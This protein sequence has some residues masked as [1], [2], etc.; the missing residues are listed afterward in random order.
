MMD[1]G[2]LRN[3]TAALGLGALLYSGSVEAQDS[4]LNLLAATNGGALIGRTTELP[5]RTA[6]HLI[7]DAGAR[8]AW[9]SSE[10]VFPQTLTFRLAKNRPFNTIVID[11]AGDT[12]DANWAKSI[13]ISTADPFPHMGGWVSV[14]IVTLAKSAGDQ[15]FT[16]EKVSGRFIRLVIDSVQGDD[17][18]RV[19]LGNVGLF[20]R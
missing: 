9:A 5:D 17:A 3:A 1:T 2:R 19:S 13:R 6:N 7:D 12:D 8:T 15:T 11:P 16:F 4:S 18:E 14:T 20:L 10:F